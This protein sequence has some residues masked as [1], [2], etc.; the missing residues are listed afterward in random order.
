MA[1]DTLKAYYKDP[2]SSFSPAEAVALALARSGSK[3]S[4]TS[5][6]LFYLLNFL[7]NI[8]NR[9]SKIGK[10]CTFCVGVC[11]CLARM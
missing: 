6:F 3:M 9:I 11:V 1:I 5:K 8:K 2:N 7:V 4:V 10:K